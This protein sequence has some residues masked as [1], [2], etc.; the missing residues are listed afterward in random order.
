VF[1]AVIQ[2]ARS[3]FGE[4]ASTNKYDPDGVPDTGNAGRFQYTGQLWIAEAGIY[5][6]KASA[7]HP[8]LG[9]YLQ[10]DP[11]GYRGSKNLYAYAGNDP[12]N[13]T[14][15]TGRCIEVY[16]LGAVEIDGIKLEDAQLD[17][18]DDEC[19]GSPNIDDPNSAPSIA[20]FTP[21]DVPG[22]DPT[23]IPSPELYQP[24]STP[25]HGPYTYGHYCGAGGTGTPVDQLDAACMQHDLCYR[26]NGFTFYSNFDDPDPNLQACN[27]KLCDA[28][29]DISGIDTYLIYP[30]PR[31]PSPQQMVEKMNADVVVAFFTH[32]PFKGNACT[33]P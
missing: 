1:G 5:H 25:V 24:S 4:G 27:Q 17:F 7:Y 15:P 2:N 9:R 22:Y 20:P 14:D 21:S 33:S 32:A 16:A 26:S 18:S 31:V 29:Q 10:T 3:R 13:G 6:F 30:V 19:F 23:S 12:V 28:A 8:G 11:I